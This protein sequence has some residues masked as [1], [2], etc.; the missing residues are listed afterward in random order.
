MALTIFFPGSRFI[1]SISPQSTNLPTSGCL[2]FG[3]EHLKSWYGA[4]LIFKGSSTVNHH[5]HID[6]SATAD[7]TRDGP[8]ISKATRSRGSKSFSVSPSNGRRVWRPIIQS[9]HFP[10]TIISD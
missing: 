1:S 3:T 7:W 5:L 4:D 8:Q 2:S 10:F 6:L 9:S